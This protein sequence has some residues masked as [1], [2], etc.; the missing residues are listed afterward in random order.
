MSWGLGR[1][2]RVGVCMWFG[3]FLKIFGG[4][5]DFYVDAVAGL[6]FAQRGVFTGVR[7]NCY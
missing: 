2:G 4:N 6:S 7:N 5:V 3:K 1:L